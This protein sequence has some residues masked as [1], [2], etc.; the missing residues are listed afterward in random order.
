MRMS[1]SPSNLGH[2]FRIAAFWAVPIAFDF[3]GV[4]CILPSVL[5]IQSSLVHGIVHAIA[6]LYTWAYLY[7][8]E[9]VPV[10]PTFQQT[11]V[12]APL[13]A[14]NLNLTW[15]L[16][17]QMVL[18][19]YSSFS[20]WFTMVVFILCQVCSTLACTTFAYVVTGAAW[21]MG[22]SRSPSKLRHILDIAVFWAVPIT[23]CFLSTQ[24]ILPSG[25]HIESSLVHAIVY[26]IVH[27][28]VHTIAVLYTWA[29]LYD[30]EAVPVA[31]TSH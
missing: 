25:L 9:A 13:P 24:L 19:A 23:F 20:S 29:Y 31:P 6:V 14:A 12:P 22:I 15:T 4:Q 1:R 11:F 17:A 8:R 21:T 3:Q 26:A 2:S 10:R 28:I 16:S 30:R 7:D 27:A 18:V 5:Q